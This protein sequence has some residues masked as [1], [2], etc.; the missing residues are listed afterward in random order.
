MTRVK[1]HALRAN[2]APYL[3]DE[4]M[5]RYTLRPEGTVVVVDGNLG[6]ALCECGAVS[7]IL[8]SRSARRVWHDAHKQ[9]VRCMHA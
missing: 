2:G 5:R 9:D 7:P 3:Y 1:G 8:N 4:W 6:R